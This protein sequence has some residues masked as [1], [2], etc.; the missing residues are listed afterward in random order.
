M[1][2]T[3]SDFMT[4]LDRDS[5]NKSDLYSDY[6]GMRS[7]YGSWRLKPFM[8]TLKGE[9]L[10]MLRC[11]GCNHIVNVG[12]MP[13]HIRA[14]DDFTELAGEM[15]KN[16]VATKKINSKRKAAPGPNNKPAANKKSKY[17]KPT[18]NNQKAETK[19]ATGQNKKP[20]AKHMATRSGRNST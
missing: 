5:D 6:N 8:P 13:G 16:Q 20:G 2:K 7:F 17:N 4:E 10:I 11:K 3:D 15:R 14:C 12:T 19:A 9:S 18:D 1:I